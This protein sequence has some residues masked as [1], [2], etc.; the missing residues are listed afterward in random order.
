[1]QVETVSMFEAYKVAYLVK[2]DWIA[3]FCFDEQCNWFKETEFKVSLD[4][5]GKRPIKIYAFS[6]DEAFERE[7]KKQKVT[8]Q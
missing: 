6:L 5:N 8:Q 1:M 2:Y 3:C 7:Q 4:S